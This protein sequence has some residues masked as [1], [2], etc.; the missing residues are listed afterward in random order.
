[1]VNRYSNTQGQYG[2]PTQR[3]T[4]WGLTWTSEECSLRPAVPCICT[5][6]R[7]HAEQ[8]ELKARV[9]MQHQPQNSEEDKTRPAAWFQTVCFSTDSGLEELLVEIID[10]AF[11]DIF[12]ANCWMPPNPIKPY[13]FVSFLFTPF[14]C[15]LWSKN[16]CGCFLKE[17]KTAGAKT[18]TQCVCV[19]GGETKGG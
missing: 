2:T 7:Q 18:T 15:Q 3:K 9:W 1:M 5:M 17:E 8:A 11:L 13:L 16:H 6:C 4:S 19:G 12:I 14:K 10:T